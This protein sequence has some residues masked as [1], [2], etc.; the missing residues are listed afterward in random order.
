MLPLPTT[1]ILLE[2]VIVGHCRHG[3]RPGAEF[4]GTKK[5]FCCPISGKMSIFRVKISDD[6]FLVI[7]LV[8]RIFPFFS[9]IFRMF[10]MLNVVYDHF[11]TRKPPFFTLS[12]LSHTSDNTASQNIRG[13]QCMGR[14]PTS[15]FGGTVPPSPLGFLVILDCMQHS[16]TVE[17]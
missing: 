17:N 8:L 9:H 3:W 6:L 2:A 7:D 14:P 13:D 5:F 12:I 1:Y 4:G 10:T 16:H 15:N 11:L